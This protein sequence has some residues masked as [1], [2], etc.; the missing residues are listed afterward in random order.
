MGQSLEAVNHLAEG[1][2]NEF[3]LTLEMNLPKRH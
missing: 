2:L 1:K 3:K